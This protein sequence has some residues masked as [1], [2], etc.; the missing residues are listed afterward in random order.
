MPATYDTAAAA[1]RKT[2]EGLTEGRE[3]LSKEEQERVGRR[4]ARLAAAEATWE[5]FLGP[6]LAQDAVGDILGIT[7]RQGVNDLCR[8]RRI[9]GLPTKEGRLYPA[10]QFKDGRALPGLPAILGLLLAEAS[11][12]SV[13]SW[14]RTPQP[15]VEGRTPVEALTADTPSDLER[16]RVAAQR[17]AA[18]LHQ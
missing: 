16:V 7:S 2:L 14:L 9:L 18:R 4:A 6:L 1:F 15:E 5:D 8:R 17:T 3:P 10:F 11:E 12:W 13:A